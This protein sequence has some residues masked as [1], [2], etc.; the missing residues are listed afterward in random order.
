M[1]YRARMPE[2]TLGALTFFLPQNKSGS[3]VVHSMLKDDRVKLEHKSIFM[4]EDDDFVDR[5][6]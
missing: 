3:K 1:E 2:S 6:G 5:L 4:T